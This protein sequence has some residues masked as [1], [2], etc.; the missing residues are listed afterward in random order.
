[1]VVGLDHGTYMYVCVRLYRSLII[2]LIYHLTDTSAVHRTPKKKL[3]S[4]KHR[5]DLDFIV[6]CQ[7]HPPDPATAT[8]TG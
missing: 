5:Y 6:I 3:T 1:M 7:Q 2:L 4:P 8:G